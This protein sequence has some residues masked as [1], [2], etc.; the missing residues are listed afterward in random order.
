M[1][2]LGGAKDRPWTRDAAVST[3]GRSGG[4]GVMGGDETWGL[5]ITKAVGDGVDGCQSLL[6]A[7]LVSHRVSEQASRVQPPDA[8]PTPIS[9]VPNLRLRK[10]WLD[11]PC[12]LPFTLFNPLL[13]APEP[14]HHSLQIPPS[15][16]PEAHGPHQ[17]T[18]HLH[19]LCSHVFKLEQAPAHHRCRPG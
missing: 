3:I 18:L 5:R 17:V 15:H 16:D 9:S 13:P 19:L 8:S 7:R 1:W 14:P 4:S 10:S 12:T 2:Q 11:W 6:T